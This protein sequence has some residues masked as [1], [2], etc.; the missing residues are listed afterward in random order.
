MS[1]AFDGDS[2]AANWRARRT[3][4]EFEIREPLSLFKVFPQ[5][6]APGNFEMT[7]DGTGFD[8]TAV[9]RV[10]WKVDGHVVGNGLIVSRSSPRLVVKQSMAGATRGIYVVRVRNFRRVAFEWLG[11]RSPVG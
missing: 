10:Y 11:V 6:V 3:D 9:D 8:E 7:L 5:V 1:A 2:N 4:S